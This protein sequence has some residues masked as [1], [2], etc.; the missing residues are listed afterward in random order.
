MKIPFEEFFFYTSLALAFL[1]LVV[2]KPNTEWRK[3]NHVIHFKQYSFHFGEI[4]EIT[5]LDFT[6]KNVSW[7][8]LNFDF[9]GG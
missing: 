2:R 9:T 1:F 4:L 6:P 5:Y 7:A 8:G 3:D